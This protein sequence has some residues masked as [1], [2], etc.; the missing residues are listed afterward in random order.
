[1]SRTF[2]S[3]SLS[4]LFYE[5]DVFREVLINNRIHTNLSFSIFAAHGS[6]YISRMTSK[7]DNIDLLKLLLELNGVLL[8]ICGQRLACSL[9][10]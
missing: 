8:S 5:R 7:R 10:S 9:N 4:F 3:L 1:M 2:L 6:I